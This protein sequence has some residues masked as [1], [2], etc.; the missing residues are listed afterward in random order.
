MERAAAFSMVLNL[1]RRRR[2]WRRRRFRKLL[3]REPLLAAVFYRRRNLPGS[4]AGDGGVTS[5]SDLNS[6]AH[7]ISGTT[8]PVG[9]TSLAG[10]GGGASTYGGGGGFGGG[11]RRRTLAALAA[12]A[13]AAQADQATTAGGGGLA[14]ATAAM[15]KAPTVR[16][17][18][19]RQAAAR[20]GAAQLSAALF[21]LD[22]LLRLPLRLAIL[23]LAK[24]MA[25]H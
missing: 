19:T 9:G 3:K 21:S 5:A 20:A 7:T 13:A 10:G 17:F 1:W 15:S 25:V 14:A 16:N 18:R 4:L 24:F 8:T 11:G 22:R 6:Y 12:S 23:V 2:S